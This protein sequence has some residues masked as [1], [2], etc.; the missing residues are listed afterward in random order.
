[1]LRYVA[2]GP[3]T[4]PRIVEKFMINSLQGYIALVIDASR[5]IGRAIT[6]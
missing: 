1:V 5:C 2:A 4:E 3:L 6:Q